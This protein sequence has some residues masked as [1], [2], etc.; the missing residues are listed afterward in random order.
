ML[1]D[2]GD[3]ENQDEIFKTWGISKQLIFIINFIDE[4]DFP[5][6]LDLTTMSWNFTGTELPDS[7]VS[8]ED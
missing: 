8:K 1:Y 6:E 3:P 7:Y 2:A 5:A 4:K